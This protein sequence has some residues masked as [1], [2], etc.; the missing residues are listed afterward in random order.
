MPKVLFVDMITIKKADV[1]AL[2]IERML[3]QGYRLS[4]VESRNY[5]RTYLDYIVE[6]VAE[7]K[8][9]TFTK[10][11]TLSGVVKAPR[12]GRVITRN[13]FVEIASRVSI[14]L[15]KSKRGERVLFT[16]VV[17][18]LIEMLDI[19]EARSR[20]IIST[21]EEC[22]DQVVAGEARLEFRGFGVLNCRFYPPR[23]A[24][25]PRDGRT[26]ELGERVGVL[27]RASESFREKCESSGAF[28]L[29]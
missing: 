4:N 21:F 5:F 3:E 27:F 29:L 28:N 2:L 13:E 8:R 7:G 22:V 16:Q 19:D 26:V 11:M 20:I 14:T 25:S 18:D 9:F 1:E 12:S 17:T 10:G 24:R 15:S 23:K 6:K